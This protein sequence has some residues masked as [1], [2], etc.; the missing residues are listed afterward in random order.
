MWA[1]F[2]VF[3]KFVTILL[4]F[5]V[6][7][8]FGHEAYGI[9]APRPGNEPTPPALE[10]EVLTTGPPGKSQC[11]FLD[12]AKFPSTGTIPLCFPLNNVWKC[13]FSPQCC[14]ERA[15]QHFDFFFFA[16]LISDKCYLS[17]VLKFCISLIMSEVKHLFIYWK[18]ILKSFYELSVHV[19]CPFYL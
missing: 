8:F 11:S 19:F 15:L 16:N 13:L 12:I 9:L 14:P 5:Y 6:F 7:W 18:S 2:K 4:L 3:I 10:G 17:K 1:I